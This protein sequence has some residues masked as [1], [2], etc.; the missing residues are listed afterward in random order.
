M[1]ARRGA[2]R[3]VSMATS[4][5]DVVGGAGDR[6]VVVAT[7][8]SVE[9]HQ[10]EVAGVSRDRVRV[11][12][13]DL[14][15]RDDGRRQPEP[16]RA[17]GSDHRD[18]GAVGLRQDDLAA[19]GEPHAGT[20]QG[21]D[22]LGREAGQGAAEDRPAPPDGLRHPERRLVPAPDG[23]GEHRDRS[24]P[25]GLGQA[26]DEQARP[27]AARQR[28]AG[29][30]AGWP[31]S[32]SAV[33][34]SAA[35]GRCGPCPGGRSARA[36]DGRTVLR[37]RPGGPGRAAR[38]LPRPP[39]GAQQ[40]HHHDHPRHRRG[41]QAGRPG[42]HPAGRR[43]ARAGRYA[44]AAAGRACGRLRRG[45]RRQGPWLPLVVVPVGVGSDPG[46]CAGRPGGR[47]HRG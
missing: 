29:P 20:V 26:E 7:R 23:A 36:V 27:R 37:G 42:R 46:G 44:A 25:A 11:S 38:V 5:V 15:G 47:L 24:G 8:R 40:D 28:R 3:A 13:Q 19:D 33:R 30:Q 39:A 4:R 22:H 1:G 18:R 34:G 32:G 9:A 12:L 21:Q 31:L 2:Y 10:D 14:P 43:Q 16:G 45:F 6:P 41:D 17:V 35:A